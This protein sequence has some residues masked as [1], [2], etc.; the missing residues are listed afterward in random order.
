MCVKNALEPQA[1]Q[2]GKMLRGFSKRRLATQ[3]SCQLQHYTAKD[4]TNCFDILNIKRFH[5]N[6]YN[7]AE[8]YS[9]HMKN[10]PKLYFIGD[11]R[12]RRWLLEVQCTQISGL[13]KMLS[14]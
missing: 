14:S 2:S 10:K 3:Y 7:I 9:G 11:S 13:T 4:T 1:Y 8:E 12:I 6:F 5:N